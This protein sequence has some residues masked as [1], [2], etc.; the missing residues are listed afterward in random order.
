MKGGLGVYLT[1]NPVKQAMLE[2][3]FHDIQQDQKAVEE[4][5]AGEFR[6]ADPTCGSFG[7]GSVALSRLNALI[8]SI[9]GISDQERGSIKQK[10][11]M[12]LLSVLI[13]HPAW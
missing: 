10:C 2:I 12:K 1:P 5:V 9:T 13:R 8:E 3:A 4:L 11:V 7:F 6:F